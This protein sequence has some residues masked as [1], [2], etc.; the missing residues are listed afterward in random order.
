MTN[1]GKKRLFGK[2]NI[3]LV[4]NV[5]VIFHS[6]QKCVGGVIYRPVAQFTQ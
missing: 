3:D 4:L 2:K 6:V 1:G 5:V